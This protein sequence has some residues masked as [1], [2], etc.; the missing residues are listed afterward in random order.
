MAASGVFIGDLARQARGC[1]V[2]LLGKPL[3]AV[4]AQGLAVGAEGV[5]LDHVHT[6]FQKSAVHVLDRLRA[7]QR[8]VIIAAEIAFTAVV[9]AGEL[10]SGQVRAHGAVKNDGAPAQYFQVI[11]MNGSC[12]TQ[13]KSSLYIKKPLR[14]ERL[15]VAYSH[16]PEFRKRFC[17]IWH[18]RL[19][20]V[21]EVSAGRSLHLSG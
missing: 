12:F 18:Q 10:L 8:Q 3:Q 20:A 19:R 2:D 5:G 11:G 16:L 6:R 17:R 4:F 15:C 1:E 9:L 14:S 7:G 21:A 13:S